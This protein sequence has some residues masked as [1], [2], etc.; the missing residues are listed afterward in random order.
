[1]T[2]TEYEALVALA[3]ETDRGDDVVSLSDITDVMHR[4]HIWEPYGEPGTFR[5]RPAHV[6]RCRRC[7]ATRLVEP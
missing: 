1:M 2:E 6:E 7:E 3:Y 5:G 4:E